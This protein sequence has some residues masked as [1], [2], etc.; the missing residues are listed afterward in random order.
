MEGDGLDL[1]ELK[2]R[3]NKKRIRAKNN[4]FYSED[5]KRLRNMRDDTFYSNLQEFN[6]DPHYLLE[7][8]R[9]NNYIFVS[10]NI[11]WNIEE[12]KKNYLYF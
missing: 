2:K 10:H 5:A 7:F 11:T 1:V 6:N 3:R 9:R 12:K 8:F 4:W